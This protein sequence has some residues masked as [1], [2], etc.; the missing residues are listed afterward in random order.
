MKHNI[1]VLSVLTERVELLNVCVE[2][3][4]TSLGDNVITDLGESNND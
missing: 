2:D 4:N 1:R 3:V